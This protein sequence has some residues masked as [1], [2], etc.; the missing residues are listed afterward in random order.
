MIVRRK[1]WSPDGGI[2]F[3]LKGINLYHD[4]DDRPHLRYLGERWKEGLGWRMGS[5][6]G[7]LTRMARWSIFTTCPWCFDEGCKMDGFYPFKGWFPGM[8]LYVYRERVY[9]NRTGIDEDSIAER[10]WRWSGGFGISKD[11]YRWDAKS[12]SSSY[13]YNPNLFTRSTRTCQLNRSA[14]RYRSTIQYNRVVWSYSCM[15][16][17]SR[18]PRS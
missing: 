16:I 17:S 8:V 7:E 15:V 12:G 18:D 14:C 1:G 6:R 3:S 10:C 13:T 11:K 2:W 9:L 4:E 5:E